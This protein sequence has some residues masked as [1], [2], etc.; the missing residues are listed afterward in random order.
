MSVSQLLTSA[1]LRS[2]KARRCVLEILNQADRPLSHQEISNSPKTRGLDKV[3][4]YRTLTS[5]QKAGLLHRVQGVNGV[6]RFGGCAVHK[7]NCSG[8]HSHFLCLTCN[9][10]FC[11]PE[12][13]LPWIVQ[14]AGAEIYA[15]QLV[16]Y[17]RCAQCVGDSHD[18]SADGPDRTEVEK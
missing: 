10:M 1:G 13:P 17:G 18:K 14:P 2:T 15:K 7:G 11:L 12:Q 8:N 3:T 6:W 9:Q 16:V 5:L 4:L